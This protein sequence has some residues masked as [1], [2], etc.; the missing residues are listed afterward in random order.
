MKFERKELPAKRME[1]KTLQFKVDSVD[2]EQGIFEGYA[3]V[4]G[5]IDSGG[6]IIE[7]G[8]FSKMLSG[9]W[10]RVKILALHNDC[11][12]PIGVP[13]ELKEDDKGLYIKGKISDTAMGKDV[14]VLLHDGVLNEMSIGY[15]ALTAPVDADGIRHL[16]EIVL[17]E[18]SLV[19]W[20]MNGEAVVT[21]YKS[22]DREVQALA[23]AVEQ[24]RKEGRKISDAR[25]KTLQTARDS[26]K[27]AVKTLDTIIKEAHSEP[28]KA[29]PAP[30]KSIPITFIF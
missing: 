17:W 8:A 6:D 7:P 23:A 14:K 20:A 25:L 27:G 10:G 26:L 29:R 28:P 3:A 4:F 18:V 1:H 9:G 24:D 21:G 30:E 13:L 19:T 16:K 11:W 5:N 22:A 2:V 12:L 15:D